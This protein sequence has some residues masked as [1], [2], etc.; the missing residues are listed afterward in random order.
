ARTGEAPRPLEASYDVEETRQTAH[1]RVD[2]V[3]MGN[4]RK[5]IAEH[6]IASKATSAHVYSVTEADVTRIAAHRQAHRGAFEANEDFKLTYT[7]YFVEAAVRALRDF[8]LVNASLEEDKILLKRYINIGVAVALPDGLIV[9]VIHQADSLN[10]VGLARAVHDL[11]RRARAGRLQPDDVQ[12]GTFS[13][14]NMGN[15]GNLFGIPVINQPQLAILGIG[16][17]QKRPVVV[18]GDAIALRHM[19]YLSLSYDHRAV[20]GALG[21]LFLE[22]I[23]WELENMDLPALGG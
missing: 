12:G 17:V 20:D 7:P 1:G 8:P 22:R 23:A 6:M 5:R 10:F 9:P 2:V 4:M 11:A 15:F 19:T 18:D 13:I 3:P 21:G 16:A 14:T